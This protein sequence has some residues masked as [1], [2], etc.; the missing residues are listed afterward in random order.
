MNNK[1]YSLEISVFHGRQAPETGT[2]VGYGAIIEAHHLPVPLPKTLSLISTKKRRYTT[3]H[4][5][6]FTPRHEPENNLY[7]QLVFALK[8]E[9]VDLLVLKKLF[10]AIDKALITEIIASETLGQYSRKLW[11]LYEWLLEEQ[12]DIPDLSTGNYVPLLDKKLQY[13]ITGTKSSRHRITNNLPGTNEFCPLVFKTDKLDSYIKANLSE[14][15]NT[16]LNTTHA[17]VLQRAASFLVLKD[18][19]ASFTIEQEHPTTNRAM[20]WG[21]AIGQAGNKPLSIEELERLQQIVIESARF[22]KLGLRQEG[23]FVGEHDRHTGEPIPEHISAKH[24]DLE[25]L[26]QGLVNANKLLQDETYDAV[27][28]A[29]TIAFGFVFIHPFEDGNGRLHR[30][31][32]HHV[33]SKKAFSQ[34][35]V[36]FPVSASILDHID[37]YRLTLESY[38]HPLLDFIE[39]KETEGHNVEVLNDTID[40]YRYFDATKQAEFLYD[41]VADTLNRVIPQEVNYLLKYDE[42]KHFIDN[43]YEMPDN[44]V[45][46]LVRFLEQNNGILSQRALKK[47]FSAL[48]ENEVKEIQ[49]FYKDLFF[50]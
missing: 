48:K 42:F 26:L 33:L 13:A 1:H 35:G 41:C 3:T 44:L 25:T 8:Y 24:E 46:L 10:V 31:L 2:L 38:S 30:Y 49:Q 11:F 28:A 5:Q 9:G 6:V 32:I 18:S 22:L 37:D 17:D 40:F 4:W 45:A 34:Q 50:E 16:Y 15:K 12:L 43:K 7:K 14:Q 21:K 19:K 29:A 27:L 39:W 36:I 23:G 47:E 20:R